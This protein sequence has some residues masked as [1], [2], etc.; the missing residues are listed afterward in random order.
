MDPWLYVQSTGKLY[1]P[2][3]SLAGS[4]Y[5]GVGTGLNNPA[6][7][8]VKNVGPI[9]VGLYSLGEVS[10]EKG[11]LTIRLNPSSSN[12]MHGRDGFLV[13][14]DN[15]LMNHTASEGCIIMPNATR[16]ELSASMEKILKV[17]AQPAPQ[18]I[19]T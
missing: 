4:G 14:G 5:S 13:H 3:G 17:I 7:Q 12:E 9:P 15:H 8:D 10:N 11:P 6:M 2:D 18:G 19:P 1:R 16:Q